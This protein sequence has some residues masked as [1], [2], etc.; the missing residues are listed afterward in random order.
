MKKSILM[1]CFALVAACVT[2]NVYF[3]AA[4]VESAAEEVVKDILGDDQN[5]GKEPEASNEQGALMPM[6]KTIVKHVN[7][8]SWII[9]TAHAQEADINVSSPAITV[10]RDRIKGR[11]ENSLK[12]FLDNQAVGF[13]N[14]GLVA[15]VDASSLGL[16]DRQV[17]N[18]LVADENRDRD[19]LYRE[20]AVAN[21]HPEWE[22]QIRE[23]FVKQWTKQAKSGWKYQN[24]AGQWQTK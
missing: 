12:P 4:E 1:V 18:K 13:T 10:L 7:P 20:I 16:K 24:E 22:D 9:S 15:V 23:A 2:I 5:T 8:V 17:V 3:P 11:Y 19:A 14:A 6:L 21:G